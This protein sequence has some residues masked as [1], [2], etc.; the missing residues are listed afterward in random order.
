MDIKGSLK[1]D[2]V[3]PLLCWDVHIMGLANVGLQLNL[4]KDLEFLQ[5]L[6]HKHLWINDLS[7]VKGRYFEAMVI[8]DSAQMIQWVSS[9]F[10]SMTG[11]KSAEVVGHTPSM[12]QGEHTTVESLNS[13]REGISK[14]DP[15]Q[16]EILNYRKN[17]QSYN[18]RIEV[19]PL[20]NQHNQTS[21]FLALEYEIKR[22]RGTQRE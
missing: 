1:S 11:Y 10:Y 5:S 8:T 4:N 22:P 19:H 9:G 7:F 12:L 16:L 2:K 13:F 17:G 3:M 21:H 18:C 20:I 6:K 15:F 14:N